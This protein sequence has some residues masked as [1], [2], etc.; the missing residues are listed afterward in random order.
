M[1]KK[2]IIMKTEVVLKRKFMGGEISQRSKSSMFS[3]TDLVRIGNIKRKELGLSNFNLSQ[4]LNSSQTKEFIEE[5]Q[6]DNERVIIKGRGRKS[7]TWVHPLLFIDI[8]LSLNPKFKVEVYKWLFDELVK[9]RNDSGESYKKMV[10]SLYNRLPKREF[11]KKI[12]KLA[13]HIKKVCEVE[14]WNKADE[15]KLKLR[16]KIHENIYLLSSVLTDPSEAVRL[17]VLNAKKDL[18][19]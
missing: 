1:C 13:N 5:L 11:P 3:A 7:N 8:A 18:K 10:G 19:K 15:D 4:Y 16:D 12:Q 14:D 6:K 9:S 17:G 2:Y